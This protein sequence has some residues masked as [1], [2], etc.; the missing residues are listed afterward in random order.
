M[1]IS[2]EKAHARSV[3]AA[4]AMTPAARKERARTAHL[5]S[6]VNAVVKRAPELS[7]EQV[8]R[9]RAVFAPVAGA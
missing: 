3:A 6:A 9:L 2:K 7:A 4:A 8:A 5:A 1:P